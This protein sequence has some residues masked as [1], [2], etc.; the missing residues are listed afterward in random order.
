MLAQA[1]TVQYENKTRRRCLFEIPSTLTYNAQNLDS[2]LRKK[3][4]SN[5][6]ST[7]PGWAPVIQSFSSDTKS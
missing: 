3:A 1:M 6:H 5:S 7:S 2:P 4:L